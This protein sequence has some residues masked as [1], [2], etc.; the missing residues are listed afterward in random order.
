M[1]RV[2]VKRRRLVY[3]AVGAT[4]VLAAN[5][6]VV[7]AFASRQVHK[8]LIT[9]PG[10]ERHHG[11][12]QTLVFPAGKRVNSVHAA[13]L[14]TGEVMLMAGSGNDQQASNSHTYRTLLW[15]PTTNGLKLVPT[16]ADVFCGGH[17]FLSNG[18][19]LIAGGT[20]RYEVLAGNVTS[21]GERWRCPTRRP[22]N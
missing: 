7:T 21:A 13:L 1:I 8:F 16:P 14:N 6:P 22:G 10:Y 9:R 19:L 11:R 5:A 12:W 17:A 18:N 3:G 2:P 20:Q 4:A 15:N